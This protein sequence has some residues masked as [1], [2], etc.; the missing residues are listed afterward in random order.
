M[1]PV[2]PGFRRIAHRILAV[3]AAVFAVTAAVLGHLSAARQAETITELSASD[4]RRLLESVVGS[5]ES[6]MLPGQGALAQS[7]AE[8]LKHVPDVVDFRILR[9]DGSEAFLDNATIREVNARLGAERF[10]L[11]PREETPRPAQAGAEHL[12][13]A[14][15]PGSGTLV[16]YESQ[17]AD[18][19]RV[20]N[21]IYAIPSQQ[22]CA[23]CH[24]AQNRHLGA[25]KLSVSMATA[26]ARI[27]AA[28]RDVWIATGLALVA[29][30]LIV[31]ALLH[32]GVVKPIQAVTGAMRRAAEGDLEQAVPVPSRDEVGQMAESFNIMAVRL[33]RLYD[34]LRDEQNKLATVIQSTGEGVV[35]T[36]G[37]GEIVLV[38]EAAVRLLGKRRERIIEDGFHN[39]LDDPK[40]VT[41]LL[42]R[43]GE[44]PAPY[45]VG[46]KGRTLRVTAATI[47]SKKAERLGSAALLRDITPVALVEPAAPPAAASRRA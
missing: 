11:R 20:V 7:Y 12:S 44:T 43:Q 25:L 4:T 33:R 40:I 38:N 36:N 34:G 9:P 16:S 41:D 28:Q 30:L 19:S 31:G 27:A 42:A 45:K 17:A 39:L 14:L 23:G 6:I 37:A 47:H 8:R 18:H 24:G 21:F 2:F 26:D 15:A 22:A 46:Y 35:V 1:N 29:V 3:V 13:R 10:A 5:I 32:T